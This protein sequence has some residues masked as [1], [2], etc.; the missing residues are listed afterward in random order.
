[1]KRNKLTETMI[2]A[3]VNKLIRDI[4]EDPAR[5][6]QSLLELGNKLG[7][8][9]SKEAFLDRASKELNN[10]DGAYYRL[11]EKVFCRADP[12]LIA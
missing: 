5:G 6:F 4:R 9:R 12:K 2:R 7:D 1:M 11:M 8:G 10:R 3:Y